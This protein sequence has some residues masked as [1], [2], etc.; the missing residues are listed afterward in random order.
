M[1]RNGEHRPSPPVSFQDLYELQGLESL[2]SRFQEFLR[3]THPELFI[4]L[5]DGRKAPEALSALR[6]STLLLNLAPAVEAFISSLFGVEEQCMALR[7]QASAAR[8]K[9]KRPLY[10]PTVEHLRSL[11]GS[12]PR[13]GFG[14]QTPVKEST[15]AAQESADC[16]ICH[17]R[18]KDS[19]AQGLRTKDGTAFRINTRDV[20]LK[21]CPLKQKISE[22]HALRAQGRVI[23]ALA[24]IIVD[25]P[26][27]PLV[28]QRICVDCEASCIFQNHEPIHTPSVETEILMRVLEMPWGVEIYSL[29]TRWNP[30]NLRTPLPKSPSGRT[31]L[32]TGLG[33]S[34]LAL[35]HYLLQEGHAVWGIDGMKIEPLPDPLN[36]TCIYSK[37][38]LWGPLEERIP[39]GM[40]GVAEYGI[41]SRWDKN[42]LTLVRLVL[43]RRPR[44]WAHGGIRLGSTFTPQD[45][46]DWGVDHI[47]L[48][49]GAGRPHVPPFA[50][51]LPLGL[52]MASDFLMALNLGSPFQKDSPVAL[53]IRLPV[54]VIGGGLTGIDAATEALA[55]YPQMVA[56]FADLHKRHPFPLDASDQQTAIE[57]LAHAQALQG[58]SPEETLT[59]LQT[60]G[61]VTVLYRGD[62]ASSPAF[63]VSPE[64][65]AWASAQGIHFQDQ[66]VVQ[67]IEVDSQGVCGVRLEDGPSLPARTVLI[68]TGTFPNTV[69]FEESPEGLKDPRISLWGDLDPAYHGSVVQAIASAK[70]GYPKISQE[71]MRQRPQ[72]TPEDVRSSVCSQVRITR[73]GVCSIPNGLV[74]FSFD[75]PLASQRFRPGKFFKLQMMGVPSEGVALNVSRQEGNRLFFTLRERGASTRALIHA[76]EDAPLL[77]MGP[78]GEDLPEDPSSP[79]RSPLQA[80]MQCMMHQICGQCLE[81]LI[82]PH[83][84]AIQLVYGCQKPHAP[85]GW[86]D[87]DCAQA[88]LRQNHL[89]EQALWAHPLKPSARSHV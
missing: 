6:E 54:V 86:L 78:L 64:E 56:R 72:S 73:A 29:L 77:L 43:E 8:P 48:A 83:T 31:V 42:F 75:A 88:R 12:Q 47:A 27:L 32:V 67:K 57:F 19:C 58:C 33:P 15:W 46:F 74:E 85:H 82:D 51:T 59:R 61:G 68:A 71:L 81:R 53:Q 41:T 7:H 10:G 45:A 49:L 2:E 60:W 87:T 23:A 38:D 16:L 62:L 25:N 13:T 9:T 28:G 63:R 22:M 5:R 34:G 4:A 70:D 79:P 52:R 50:E 35:S 24:M 14:C 36:K 44:F 3:P 69:L 37:D 1:N 66:G 26:L 17:E 89:L 39:G 11:N 80:P 30:L 18:A 65:V 84:G 20:P 76:P 40:G 55:Y 21:G